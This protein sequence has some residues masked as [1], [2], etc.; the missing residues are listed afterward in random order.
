VD[1][2][3]VGT[4][5]R[6]KVCK[7]NNVLELG[8]SCS[9]AYGRSPPADGAKDSRGA[10]DVAWVGEELPMFGVWSADAKLER[11]PTARV[12]YARPYLSLTAQVTPLGI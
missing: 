4:A 3:A 11:A 5:L 10:G 9:S 12:I 7:G 2:R 8:L 1:L 6:Y